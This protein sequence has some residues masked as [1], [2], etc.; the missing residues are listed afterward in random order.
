MR[1]ALTTPGVFPYVMGGI[2]RHSF[3]L[4]RSLARLGVRVDL[5][6]TDFRGGAGIADLAGMSDEERAH[7]TS[8]PIPWPSGDSLPG[9]YVRELKRFSGRVLEVLKGRCPADLIYG[10]GIT[11]WAMVEAK[12]NGSSLPPIVVNLHGFEMFQPPANWKLR[13]QAAMMRPSFAAHAR[14]ADFVASLGGHLTTLIRERVGVESSRIIEIPG[15]IDRDWNVSNPRTVNDVR[16]F[17]FVGRYERRKGIE[18]LHEVIAAHPEWRGRAVFRFIGPIPTEKRLNSPHVSYA[19]PIRE[20]ALLQEELRASDVLL[21]PSYSEGMPTVI[22]EGMASGLGVIATDVGAV[23]VLV[24]PN[25]GILLDRITTS[26][27]AGAIAQMIELPPAGLFKM[28][29]S[30]LEKV[31]DFNW[32][33]VGR[34]TL[35]SFVSCIAEEGLRAKRPCFLRE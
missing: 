32:D 4:A 31:A 26:S 5:Y 34:R 15:A 6:H 8:I 16:R 11:A 3:N 17:V 33:R 20:E 24:S 14:R 1:I 25:N 2:Q 23:S 12:R 28:K 35:D 27:L 13:A 29:C 30:S 22:L 19:G 9:H 10:Q 18:E 7:V 21:C